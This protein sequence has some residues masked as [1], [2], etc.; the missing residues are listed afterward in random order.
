MAGGG[1]VS[2]DEPSDGPFSPL[3]IG[4]VAG[5]A[6]GIC[7]LIALVVSVT[8]LA[9]T[10]L[11]MRK[12]LQQESEKPGEDQNGEECVHVLNLAK[13]LDNIFAMP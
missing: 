2:S 7:F 9:R 13:L 11:K 1:T 6:V 3:I 8:M 10:H 12:K 5:A 4:I